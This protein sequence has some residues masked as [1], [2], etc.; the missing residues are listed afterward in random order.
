MSVKF[1]PSPKRPVV[2]TKRFKKMYK[3]N[4][5]FELNDLLLEV[6]VQDEMRNINER[7]K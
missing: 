2:D 1:N 5:F 3:E 4:M 7:I 6:L